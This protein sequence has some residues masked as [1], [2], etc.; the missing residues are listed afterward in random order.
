MN[1]I[2]LINYQSRKKLSLSEV[3]QELVQ[4]KKLY[5][6]EVPEDSWIDIDTNQD[7]L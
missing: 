6:I 3:I 2:M 7:L 4:Q 1:L 5:F